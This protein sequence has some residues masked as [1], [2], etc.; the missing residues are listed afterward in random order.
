MESVIREGDIVFVADYGKFAVVKTIDVEG[1]IY[2]YIIKIKEDIN[3]PEV[4]FV[5]EKIDDEENLELIPVT[6]NTLF[7]KLIVIVRE[8]LMA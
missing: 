8:K 4:L 7:N 6:D 5:T 3:N 2:H 1:K